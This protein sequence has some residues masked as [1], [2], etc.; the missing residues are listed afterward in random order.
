MFLQDLD[1]ESYY[2]TAS[3]FS[4][5]FSEG[6]SVITFGRTPTSP[7]AKKIQ[8]KRKRK[9]VKRFLQIVPC[10]ALLVLWWVITHFQN[11]HQKKVMLEMEKVLEE[12]EETRRGNDSSNISSSAAGAEKDEFMFYNTDQNRNRIITH[13]DG[14]A[15]IH[16][17]PFN[18]LADVTEPM[19]T[20]QTALFWQ[21][22]KTGGNDD[23]LLL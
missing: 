5:I 23:V 22:P 6:M 8:R 19:T 1:D 14:V 11:I 18:G 15:S 10:C 7:G 21:I 9:R 16:G 3:R 13:I 4:T 17:Y 12:Q 20:S 2:S